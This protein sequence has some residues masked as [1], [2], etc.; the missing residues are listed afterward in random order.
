LGLAKDAAAALGL[1]LPPNR[2]PT[3]FRGFTLARAE[4]WAAA[5]CCNLFL[6]RL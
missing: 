5:G 4:R 3:A 1:D 6:C 2:K